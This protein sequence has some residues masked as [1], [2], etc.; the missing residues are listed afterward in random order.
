M[1]EIERAC[2]RMQVSQDTLTFKALSPIYPLFK[3]KLTN[4][5]FYEKEKFS[6]ASIKKEEKAIIK[7]IEPVLFQF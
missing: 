3:E 2:V 7:A 6:I 1:V 5:K 4:Q